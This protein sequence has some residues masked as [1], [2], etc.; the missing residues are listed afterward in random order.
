MHLFNFKTD[1]EKNDLIL[2]D[3]KNNNNNTKQVPE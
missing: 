1:T 3:N 2:D